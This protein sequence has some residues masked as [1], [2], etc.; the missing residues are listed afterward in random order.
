MATYICRVAISHPSI[1][2]EGQRAR[3]ALE[4]RTQRHRF[5]ERGQRRT[6]EQPRICR[7]HLRRPERSSPVCGIT[8]VGNTSA[9]TSASP[10]T[11][12]AVLPSHT[13]LL[14]ALLTILS[15]FGRGT[16]QEPSQ[17]PHT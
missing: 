11:M 16:Q 13:T 3:E 8:R 14:G 1:W 10:N 9:I 6:G 2:A 5:T 12:E 15:S 7:G 17:A 4:R